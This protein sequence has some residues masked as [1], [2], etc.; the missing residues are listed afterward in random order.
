MKSIKMWSLSAT[1]RSWLS[2]SH[3]VSLRKNFTESALKT[4]VTEQ[5]HCTIFYV[6]FYECPLGGGSGFRSWRG[7]LVIWRW[8][9]LGS[10][11]KLPGGLD[12]HLMKR[13]TL[14]NEWTWFCP[15]FWVW[16]EHSHIFMKDSLGNNTL[17]ANQS[18]DRMQWKCPWLWRA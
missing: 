17:E 18:C 16:K 6:I 2:F 13:R 7:W 1:A 15:R 14:G 4:A 10:S 11:T 5:I 9:W 3:F 8:K 12:F